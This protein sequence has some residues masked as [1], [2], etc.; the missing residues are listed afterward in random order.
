MIGHTFGLDQALALMD[1]VAADPG[2]L[3]GVTEE[4]QSRIIEEPNPG[5]SASQ[6][7]LKTDNVSIHHSPGLMETF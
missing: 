4:E 3:H 2:I 1:I 6:S 5:M 7:P